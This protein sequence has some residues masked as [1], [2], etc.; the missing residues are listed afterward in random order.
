M[1]G[2]RPGGAAIGSHRGNRCAK[3]NRHLDLNPQ[4]YACEWQ[5]SG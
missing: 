3:D 5:M 1:P 2:R 4:L